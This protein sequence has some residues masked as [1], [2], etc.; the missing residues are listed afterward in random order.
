MATRDEYLVFAAAAY[1][2]ARKVANVI[3]APNGWTLIPGPS[4]TNS[5][6]LAFF[7]SGFSATAFRNDA[8]DEIVIS[9]KGTD[10]LPDNPGQTVSDLLAD[11]TLGTGLVSSSQLVGAALFYEHIKASNPPG[12]PISF[13]GHSLGAGLASVMSVWFNRPAT[14]FANAPF[15]PSALSPFALLAVQTRLA[16]AG[17]VDQSFRDFLLPGG[18]LPNMAEFWARESNVNGHYVQGELLHVSPLGYWPSVMGPSDTPIDFGGGDKL[19]PITLHSMALH[20]TL[21]MEDKFRAITEKLPFLLKD[22]FDNQLYAHGPTSTERDFLTHLLKS[23]VP[24]LGGDTSNG[25]L[26]HF[27]GDLEK[28]TLEGVVKQERINRALTALAIEDYYFMQSGFTNDFFHNVTGGIK[29]DLNDIGADSDHRGRDKLITAVRESFDSEGYIR[30]QRPTTWYFQAGDD[31]MVASSSYAHNTAMIGGTG[32]DTLTSGAGNDYL[33]GGGGID[34]LDGGDG[35]DVLV[36]GGDGDKLHG[37]VGKDIYIVDG[38]DEI[39]DSDG[40]GVIKDKDGNVINGF[41]I[42]SGDKQYVWGNDSAVTA[43]KQGTDFTLNLLDGSSVKIEN[44]TSGDFGIVFNDT[45]QDNPITHDIKGDIIP[46]DNDTEEEGLQIGHNPDGTLIGNVGAIRDNV[47]GTA[48][49][50]YITVGGDGVYLNLLYGGDGDDTLIGSK[51]AQR[52]I[53][54]RPSIATQR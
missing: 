50:D 5:G 25:L 31:A 7:T 11:L 49:N 48:N 39:K 47:T 37:G 23:Q 30:L 6:A 9:F 12:T 41:F 20:A 44:F 40:S 42:K 26:A 17:A 3:R 53:L 14:V 8:S 27:A 10:F 13:T 34:T 33:Y 32:G 19:D 16:L 28:I 18:L 35:I 15:Q 45:P 46:S 1:D 22:I 36:G 29:F 52:L 51:L 38:N 54:N 24:L 2:D 4:D 43:T 21:L